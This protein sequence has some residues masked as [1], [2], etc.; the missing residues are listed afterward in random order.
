MALETINLIKPT[1]QRRIL[2]WIIL[3]T[4]SYYA[5]IFSI[6]EVEVASRGIEQI[7]IMNANGLR[8]VSLTPHQIGE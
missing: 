6:S 1:P 8:I 4:A 3:E 7:Q 5:Q 2:I